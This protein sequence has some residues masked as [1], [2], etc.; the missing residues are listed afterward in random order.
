MTLPSPKLV[1]SPEVFSWPNDADHVPSGGPVDFDPRVKL[2]EFGL[3][4]S[5][6]HGV[7]AQ[8]Q[9]QEFLPAPSEV[10]EVKDYFGLSPYGL[11]G[12]SPRPLAATLMECSAHIVATTP[13]SCALGFGATSILSSAPCKNSSEAWVASP[14]ELVL[15]CRRDAHQLCNYI[16]NP[17]RSEAYRARKHQHTKRN[18]NGIP[19]KPIANTH[20]ALHLGI[21]FL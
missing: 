12:A 4:P 6:L 10:P 7:V 15:G 5:G 2:E 3:M 18:Q 11:R 17:T 19:I 8:D 1:V 21:G 16:F 13:R 14:C 9:D 20:C